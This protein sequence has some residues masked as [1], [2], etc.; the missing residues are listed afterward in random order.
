M[1]KCSKHTCLIDTH[2]LER[3]NNDRS[4]SWRAENYSDFYGKTLD[5]GYKHK[6]GVKLAHKRQ[7]DIFFEEDND[8]LADYDFRTKQYFSSKIKNQEMCGA[9]W[10]YS[11]A[12][13]IYI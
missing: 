4:L 8:S 10:A 7:R 2:L 9:S 11:M 1:F 5:H 6:L 13:T 3:I 12:G